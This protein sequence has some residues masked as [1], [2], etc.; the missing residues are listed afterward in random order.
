[1]DGHRFDRISR[2][3]AHGLT[4]RAA[5]RSAGAGGLAA[6]AAAGIRRAGA[7]ETAACELPLELAVRQGPN[8]GLA[9]RGTLRLALDGDGGLSGVYL[10][11]RDEAGNE[12][13]TATPEGDPTAGTIE[14]PVV[15]Q[16]TGRAINLMI[17][18]GDGQYVFGVGTLE[19]PL[20]QC[21][22]E[23][24]G[25]F[26]G[27]E[28]GDTGDWAPCSYARCRAAGGTDNFCSGV[29][30]AYFCGIVQSTGG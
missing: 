4:R 19:R 16:A 17:T 2:G 30:L 1:M 5:L 15:G 6:A 11:R 26:V 3:L 23:M 7:Q 21:G 28:A 22:G 8:A 14:L 27:P 24:G 20:D 10:A 13:A 18:V 29:G 25:P 9:W 12:V